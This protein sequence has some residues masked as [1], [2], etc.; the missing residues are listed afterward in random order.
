[1]SNFEGLKKLAKE[2]FNVDI[3][4]SN[5]PSSFEE[6]FG[7]SLSIN[8]IND[9][10]KAL[11]GADVFLR[12]RANSKP[13]PLNEYDKAIMFDIAKTCDEAV[14]LISHYESEIERISDLVL[15][16]I[17]SS[18]SW[19]EEA[20]HLTTT[21]KNLEYLLSQAYDRI[22]EL[23]GLGEWLPQTEHNDTFGVD[24]I[25]HYVC[26][27]CGEIKYTNNDRYCSNCGKRMIER[28]E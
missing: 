13:A 18:N 14:K 25:N 2:E 16:T 7:N 10:K 12:D 20:C 24:L 11:D 19:M 21:K 17:E 28:K 23:D 5:T 3:E 22:E 27:N 26:S 9:I 8:K 1:M 6:V 15:E 4:K